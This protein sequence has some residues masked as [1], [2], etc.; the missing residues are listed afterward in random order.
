MTD[1]DLDHSHHKK[2]YIGHGMTHYQM[3]MYYH[4]CIRNIGLYLSVTFAAI[5]YAQSYRGR[6]PV[7]HLLLLV[8]GL[9]TL[10]ISTGMNYFLIHDLDAYMKNN[11]NNRLKTW[12][13]FNYILLISQI[14]LAFLSI[15]IIYRNL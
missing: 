13:Y 3:V 9:I 8:L 10:F 12:K 11:H 15:A 5:G 2:K 4:T 1:I 6:R 7:Y 14:A